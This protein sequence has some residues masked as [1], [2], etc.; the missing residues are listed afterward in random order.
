MLAPWLAVGVSVLGLTT[1]G[2]ATAASTQGAGTHRAPVHVINLRQA[3][4]AR[5]GHPT[6]S[7]PP[8]ILYAK[9]DQPPSHG[10]G[11]NNCAEPY[12]PLTY[13]GG[14]VQHSPHV[15]LLLWGPDWSTDPNQAATATQLESFYSGLGVTPDDNWS[16]TTSQYSDGTG[17]P[18]F[19]GSVYEGV[20]QDTS[21]PPTGVDQTGLAAEAD[22]FT[23]KQGITDLSD[24]QIVVATQSGTCPAGFY[25]PSCNGG[26]GYY[27]AWHSS[28]NEPYVNLPYVLDAGAP[29]GENSVNTNGTYDG[30]SIAAAH[31]Y[32]DTI[33]DPSLG[34]AWW[35]PTDNTGGEVADKCAWSAFSHDVSLSTGIFAMPPLWSNSA[36]GCV[37]P[38]G[39]K[40]DHVTVANPGKQSTYQ[41]SALSLT[42]D[43]TSTGKHPLAWTATGL[44]PGLTIGSADGV[45]TGQIQAAPKTYK[46]TVQASDSTGA[47]GWASFSWT[48]KADVGTPIT[49]VGAGK[50]LNDYRSSITPKNPVVMWTCKAG[51]AEKW[52]HPTNTGELIVL[53]QCLTNPGSGGKAIQLI[54]PCTGAAS[55]EWFHNSRGEFVVE[56][57]QQ[58]LTDPNDSTLNGEPVVV[59]KCTGAKDQLWSGS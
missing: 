13:H 38:I 54:D 47:F 59:E 56:S 52:S 46:V 36:G 32:A 45:I 5:L 27:C 28:S 25:A 44:P 12:C 40:S 57:T 19:T 39:G 21:T 7:Q 15:Y 3:Y 10:R 9:P 58:C 30:L 41:G 16:T 6:E 11:G 26:S 35:D 48:V 20:W 17:R 55:Q 8:G 23:S 53:G 24:A 49:N 1:A 31:E 43:G 34:S 14:L 4:E 42:V 22:A 51:A 18:I 33:T 37:M 29:C 50:C 2:G